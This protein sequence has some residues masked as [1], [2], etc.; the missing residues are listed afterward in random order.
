MLDWPTKKHAVTLNTAAGSKEC[1][2]AAE[3]DYKHGVHGDGEDHV[4]TMAH[5]LH[6][7]RFGSAFAV[8]VKVRDRAKV[9]VKKERGRRWVKMAAPVYLTNIF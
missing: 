7:L 4:I 3:Q 5:P 6:T 2:S 1:S 9:T 8:K